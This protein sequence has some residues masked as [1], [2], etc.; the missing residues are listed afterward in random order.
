VSDRGSKPPRGVHG[1]A[2]APG[3][4]NRLARQA[5]VSD[6]RARASVARTSGS[7]KAVTSGSFK[8]VTGTGGHPP[9][10]AS[11]R[12]SARLEAVERYD[13][14][15]ILGRIGRGGMAEILLARERSLT[16]A[17]RH[18]VIKRVL[19]EVRDFDEMLHMFLDETRVVMGLSHPNLC[20]IY[21][22]GE[23]DGS[24][25][26][27]MEWVNGV[28]LHQLLR[29]ALEITDMDYGALARIVSQTSDALHYAHT[30]RD[31]EGQLMHLVHRDVSPHNVMVAFDGRV[32]LLDFGIA[33]SAHTT[34][35]TEAGVV[36]GKICYM[37][38]EQWRRQPVDGRTDVF[39]LGACLFEALC[40][41]VVFKRESQGEVMK[42]ALEGDVPRLLD[43]APNTPPA[44][45]E[46]AHK[47]LATEPDQRF[48][49]ARE[50]GEALERFIST[51]PEPVSTARV[52]DYSR[53]LFASEVRLGPVLER[54]LRG[55][56]LAPSEGMFLPPLPQ[57]LLSAPPGGASLPV[58][59]P[60]SFHTQPHQ[61]R[62]W[63][64]EGAF[65]DDFRPTQ[66]P[67]MSAVTTAITPE[68]LLPALASKESPS[69]APT[70]PKLPSLRELP[71]V[72]LPRQAAGTMSLRVGSRLRTVAIVGALALAG[73]IAVA[74][75]VR[76][77]LSEEPAHKPLIVSGAQQ[78]ELRTGAAQ[79]P[80]FTL[81]PP[82]SPMTQAPVDTVAEG[83][84]AQAQQGRLSINTRPWST[85]YLGKRM[86]G[87]TP[88]ADVLVPRGALNLRLVDRD[89]NVHIRRV[90]ASKD[91][92]RSVSFEF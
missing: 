92:D 90:P 17:V 32:K 73:S 82:G 3:D 11:W 63:P 46:I 59:L 15:E 43:L 39:A 83:A 80:A 31:E 49:T 21:E 72:E 81:L 22:I 35:K 75:G 51:L 86:L 2:S 50:M 7:H 69:Q 54:S 67:P 28:T 12:P 1:D 88:L 70:R 24:W 45:A 33:K 30:A 56:Q 19:P 8:A 68:K 38:P 27:A 16:G 20:Q 14:F 41:R 13:R 87:T 65:D 52:S 23:H 76:A 4:E 66:R 42:A 84:P 26:I 34:H 48:Q 62:P 64:E 9:A 71:I 53:R 47:A 37:A 40:G 18:L 74:F 60:F 61:E 55:A 29:R 79:A 10:L 25:F 85:V 6:L 57:S 77:L 36:K 5:R 44:L 91:R 78:V 89:G 58:P